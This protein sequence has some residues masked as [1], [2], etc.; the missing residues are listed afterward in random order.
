MWR[1]IKTTDGQNIGELLIGAE[2]GQIITFNTGTVVPVRETF[3]N[4]EETQLMVVSDNYQ[5]TL[6]KEEKE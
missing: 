4:K 2:A 6:Q 1:V 3:L 5:L